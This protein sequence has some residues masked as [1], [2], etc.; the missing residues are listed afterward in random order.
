MAYSR[1]RPTC[2]FIAPHS[3][4]NDPCGA[5]YVPESRQ[6]LICYQ[7]N[8]G[9][10]EGGNCA[11]G[12]AKSDDL[13][14]WQDCMPAIW[15]GSSYDCAGVFSGSI[16][17][18]LVDGRRVLYLFYTSVSA[19]PIHWS[20]PY[21]EGCETQSVAISTDLGQTW[22]RHAANPLMRGP[23]RAAATTGWRDPF[24]SPSR[25]LSDALGIS[26]LTDYMLLASGERGRGPE[27]HLYKSSDL[28]SWEYVSLLLDVDLHSLVSDRSSR[29][30]GISFECAS[31]FSVGD[32]DYLVV[33]VEETEGSKHHNGH[34]ILWLGGKFVL[35]GATAAPRFRIDSHSMLDHGILYAAHVFRD[36]ENRLLQLGWADETA[37]KHVVQGQGWAG[38]LG[39]PRELVQVCRPL[40]ARAASWPEW[41]VDDAAGTM[42][43][44]GV[45]PAPQLEKL[46]PAAPCSLASFSRLQSQNYEVRATFSNLTGAERFT[47]NVL[48]AP[49]SAEV[50]RIIFDTRRQEITV[51]RSKSSLKQL[52]T[53]TPDSGSLR[54]LPGEHLDVRVF[55]DVSIIEVYANDRFALTSRVYPSLDSSTGASCDFGDFPEAGVS[56]ECWHG[57]QSAWPGR[58]LGCGMLLPELLP[59]AGTAVDSSERVIAVTE[60]AVE[61]TAAS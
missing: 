11:W 10:T 57:L 7:W 15:N 60:M 52:G 25:S 32:T 29:R 2:H 40:D 41:Q 1:H 3:W 21:L 4:S 38:C 59:K 18:R 43:T 17:S 14:T 13:V 42:T 37:K 24:V 47:L 9:T 36:E 19:V 61:M 26:R 49:D 55:V 53:A 34:Y 58:E 8:P 48:Q 31:F 46:R 39:L 5:V 51:D 45:R 56:F 54:L 50:T 20:K 30:W 22:V 33:G 23:P 16:V 35:D 12:M 27:L 6:Y 44:L 28:Q